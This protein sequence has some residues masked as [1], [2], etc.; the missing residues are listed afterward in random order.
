M[1]HLSISFSCNIFLSYWFKKPSM[2][3]LLCLS[4]Y[5]GT[6]PVFEIKSDDIPC[7]PFSEQTNP[8]GLLR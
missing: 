8:N 4:E 2:N 3:T 7:V 5:S 6:T 1:Y